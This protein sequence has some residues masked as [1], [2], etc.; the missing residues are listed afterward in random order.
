MQAGCSKYFSHFNQNK[1]PCSTHLILLFFIQGQRWFER[2]ANSLEICCLKIK[3]FFGRNLVCVFKMD[4]YKKLVSNI[5]NTT[6]SRGCLNSK[7]RDK[8]NI[9]G[10]DY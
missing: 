8:N 3:E 6:D 1:G 2:P 4:H 9:A 5:T 10:N 7:N